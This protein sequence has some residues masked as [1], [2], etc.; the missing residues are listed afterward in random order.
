MSKPFHSSDIVHDQQLQQFSLSA[1]GETALLQYR[2]YL[3]DGLAAV[4]FYHTFVP[5]AWRGRQVAALLT[6]QAISWA[7]AQGLQLHASCS[8]VAA[9]LQAAAN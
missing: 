7:T 3:Q 6:T 5:A 2:L 8:Y 1:G 9:R 4:D